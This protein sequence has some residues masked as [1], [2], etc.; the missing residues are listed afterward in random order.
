MDYSAP[1]FGRRK[2]RPPWQVGSFGEILEDFRTVHT[3][4][5]RIIISTLW[6]VSGARVIFGHQ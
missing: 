5:I 3:A 6:S 2:F 1:A 4:G